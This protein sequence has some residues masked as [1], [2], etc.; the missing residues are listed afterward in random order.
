MKIN[1]MQRIS[2]RY[3][4]IKEAQNDID[5]VN[6]IAEYILDKQKNGYISIDVEST[7]KIKNNI[8]WTTSINGITY[9]QNENIIGFSVEVPDTILLEAIGII[10]RNKQ[11][12]IKN[13]LNDNNF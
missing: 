7:E 12:R 3:D 8:T 6:K 4:M 13:L 10:L 9:N 2:E 5:D 1:D 11:Q